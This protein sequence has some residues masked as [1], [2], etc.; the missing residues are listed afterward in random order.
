MKEKLRIGRSKVFWPFITQLYSSNVTNKV[1]P[2][3]FFLQISSV[4]NN[5]MVA[6]VLT[7]N[8]NVEILLN[9]AKLVKIQI[10]CGIQ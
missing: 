6:P 4:L 1:N 5:E 2:L 7:F 9:P 10:T 8:I 3:L